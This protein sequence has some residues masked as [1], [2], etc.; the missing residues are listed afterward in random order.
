MPEKTSAQLFF[1]EIVKEVHQ[2]LKPLGFKK[3]ALNFFREEHGLFQLI[4]IQKSVYNGANAIRFTLNIC[5]NT[6]QPDNEWSIHAYAIRERI[7]HLSVQQGDYW[8]DLDGEIVDI[9]QRKQR[10]LD[11]K[12]QL[13][14]DIENL[15][16]PFLAAQ[17]PQIEFQE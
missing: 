12:S 13:L 17:M 3:K 5:A 2:K 4:N 11:E 9:V 7:G 14:A 10:F 16:L 1:D 6:Q 15:V 8:Y